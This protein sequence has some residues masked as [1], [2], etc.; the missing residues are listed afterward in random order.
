MLNVFRHTIIQIKEQSMKKEIVYKA[1]PDVPQCFSTPSTAA[2]IAFPFSGAL[3]I[4]AM[5]S[6]KH[7]A[8]SSKAKTSPFSTTGKC[9]NFPVN[10]YQ[11]C[12]QKAGYR[13]VTN[14]KSCVS[15]YTLPTLHHLLE[16]FCSKSFRKNKY[17]IPSH[18]F[19]NWCL[20]KI[21]LF[22]NNSCCY[23]LYLTTK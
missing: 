16:G 11:P 12:I 17:R 5:A 22:G 21:N 3:S 9:L 15:L 1:E 20:F 7:F 4:R 6:C 19:G 14:L 8:M 18:D 23:I 13:K 2:A 10:I